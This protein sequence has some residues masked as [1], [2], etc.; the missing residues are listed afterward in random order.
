MDCGYGSLTIIL[1]QPLLK[2]SWAVQGMKP[3]SSHSFK[4]LTSLNIKPPPPPPP[5]TSLSQ[6]TVYIVSRY[7]GLHCWKLTPII[8]FN[9]NT[10]R[11]RRNI[12]QTGSTTGKLPPCT[13][14]VSVVFAVLQQVCLLYQ[15]LAQ[16]QT[17]SWRS[18][19]ANHWCLFLRAN[20]P[21]EKVCL[22]ST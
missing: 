20:L 22:M 1:I 2:I 16:H 14:Q 5:P 10:Q 6:Q 17:T 19:C 18:R 7:Q 8:C 12:L 9:W 3:A 15:S 4:I 13:T 21:W 11:T